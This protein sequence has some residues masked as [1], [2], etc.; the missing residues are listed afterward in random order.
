LGGTDRHRV[1][2]LPDA[3]A[4]TSDEVAWE[5]NRDGVITYVSPAVEQHLGYQPVEL[6]GQRWQAVMPSSE[7]ARAA[8]LIAETIAARGRWDNEE[9]VVTARSGQLCPMLSS[10]LAQTDPH[11][12]VIGVAGTVRPL[13][14]G[15][16]IAGPSAQQLIDEII[17]W[18]LIKP[19]FQ[20]IVELGDGRPIAVEV[21][22]RFP[23]HTPRTAAQ[24]FGHAAALNV[25]VEL[26]LAAIETALAEAEPVPQQLAISL[27]T[28]P[29]TLRTGR[30]QPVIDASGIDPRRLIIEITEQSPVTE[31][32]PLRIALERLRA[33]GCRLAVDDA[34]AG[35]ASFKHIITLAPDWIKLDRFLVKDLTKDPAR[36]ALIRAVVGFASEVGVTIVA[37]GIESAGQATALQ[38][39]GV[40]CGQGYYI[41]PPAF[42]DDLAEDLANRL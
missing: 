36:R 20:P 19:V 34:G 27:N 38:A 11:G 2:P 16:V 35:Y 39:L 26:E 14:L 8:V 41:A 4:A 32:A 23:F 24:I 30:L 3:F 5:L 28:S 7:H 21:L 1:E 25:G 17:G 33:K 29:D 31:Y 12:T 13:P 40:Q 9:Y 6:I 18:R 22:S 10:G 15:P 37:E 42:A